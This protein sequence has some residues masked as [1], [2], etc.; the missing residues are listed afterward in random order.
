MLNLLLDWQAGQWITYN[1]DQDPKVV[2]N[3]QQ[4]DFFNSTLRFGKTFQIKK[5]RVQMFVDID[6]LF[7]NKIMS[8]ANFEDSDDRKFYNQSLH[9]PESEDYDNIPGNDRMGDYRKAG[10]DYQPVEQKGFIDQVNDVGEPG[11]IYY[12]NAT[13]I[14]LN[15]NEGAWAPVTKERMNKILEDKAYIDMPNHTCF[16]FLNPRQIYFGLRVSF[17]LN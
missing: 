1:P 7:N 14:Y 3:V 4:R 8:L 11:V 15:Y 16:T 13:G 2:N 17:D 10:V 9:L 12:E 6:N 5:F